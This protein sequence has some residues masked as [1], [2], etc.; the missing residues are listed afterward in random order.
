[1]ACDDTESKTWIRVRDKSIFHLEVKD[2]D[3]FSARMTVNG[4]EKPYSPGQPTKLSSPNRYAWFIDVRHGQKQPRVEAR[5]E[6]PN[7]VTHGDPYC[8]E[9]DGDA[10]EVDSITLSARTRTT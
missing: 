8:S 5:I 1:M 3:A 6:R 9:P 10:G 2:A 4:K 7:G